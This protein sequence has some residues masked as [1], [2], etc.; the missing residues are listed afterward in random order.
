M[1]ERGLS[2]R[3][4]QVGERGLS[5]SA[6]K[7][8]K[9]LSGNTPKRGRCRG[10]PLQL[11]DVHEPVRRPTARRARAVRAAHDVPLVSTQT[12]PV[13][14]QS[15]PMSTQSTPG[16]YPEYPCEYSENPLVSNPSTACDYSED[17]SWEPNG[18]RRNRSGWSDR[19]CGA[20]TL[21]LLSAT[22]T[23]GYCGFH[24]VLEYSGY[25]EYWG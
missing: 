14:T 13:S 10:H 25:S 24:K 18:G 17:P 9:F 15:T 19:R 23:A 5:G 7:R 11:D 12:T 1:G 3:E 21:V 8:E 4:G 6:A 2:G 16:E 20:R 22:S